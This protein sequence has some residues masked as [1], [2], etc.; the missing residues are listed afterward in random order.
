LVFAGG[1]SIR[2]VDARTRRLLAEARVGVDTGLNRVAFTRDGALLVVEESGGEGDS[3]WITVRDASTLKPIG[4]PIRP[5]GFHGSFISE[6]WT[7][8]SIALTPD[9]RSLVTASPAG[10]LA[11]WDLESRTKTRAIEIDVGQRALALSPDGLTAAVGLDRGIRLI[12]VRTR[13]V[14]ET[15]GALTSDPI[16]LR[17]SP[18]GE[19]VVSTS[20]DGTVTLWDAETVVPIETLRGHSRA[21]QQPAFSPDGSTLYT[22]SHDGTAI[23]WDLGGDRRLGRRFTFTHDRGSHSWPDWHPGAFS[24]DGR[25]IAVGLKNDGIQLW[26]AR[27]L[28]PAGPVMRETFG[29]VTALAFTPDGRTLIAVSEGGTASVWDLRSRSLRH[30]S[31]LGSY[32]VGVSVSADGKTFAAAGGAAVAV[33]EVATGA[34]VT[35]VGFGAA[36]D[37]A[38]SPTQPLV[39][40]AR[41]GVR[42]GDQADAEIWDVARTVR[43]RRLDTDGDHEEYFL[44]W[45]IA[46]SPDGRLLASPGRGRLVNL[47][48]VATGRLV[49]AFEHN[50]GTAVHSLEFSP[51][52]RILAISGGDSFA[53]LW[54]V[55]TGTQIGPRLAAG[56][57]ATKVEFSPDGRRLLETH[58]NGEGAVWDVDPESW[59]RRACALANRTLTREEWDEFLPGRPYEPAC[60]A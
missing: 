44:G 9:G 28:R 59:K 36:G 39:A 8:P 38:L 17:F 54:D 16:W 56:G 23:A 43:I 3:T 46:F 12:D 37:V 2:L 55:A 22:V 50:V 1:D 6:F 30:A 24:P 21:V 33:R 58:A 48:D 5:D 34:L 7:D 19:T 14:R 41:E 32:T 51:D 60:A 27:E 15:N 26:A 4:A 57:R 42:T 18:D 45:A 20:R 40:F 49:R 29:E 35:S 13:A 47:W 10:E 31:Y 52:G 25:L 53:S 11:W